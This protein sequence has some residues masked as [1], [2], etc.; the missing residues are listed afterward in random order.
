MR[1][2]Q[3]PQLRPG[4]KAASAFLAATNAAAL[5]ATGAGRTGAVTAGGGGAVR[6]RCNRRKISAKIVSVKSDTT[7][8]ANVS[9]TPAVTVFSSINFLVY[10]PP[11]M[12][13][14]GPP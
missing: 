6:T 11:L 5:L 4:F 2:P 12:C 13:T 3:W 14:M 7:K 9:Q 10:K 8:L 1:T